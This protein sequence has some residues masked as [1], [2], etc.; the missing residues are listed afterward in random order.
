MG[1]LGRIRLR[2]LNKNVYAGDVNVFISTFT[3]TP[4]SGSRIRKRHVQFLHFLIH[5][6]KSAHLNIIWSASLM[7]LHFLWESF[8]LSITAASRIVPL[9]Q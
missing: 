2:M 5:N 9:W 7:H 3:F 4:F 1:S 8:I 6:L